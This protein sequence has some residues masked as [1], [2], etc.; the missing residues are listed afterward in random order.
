MVIA[1]PRQPLLPPTSAVAMATT[2][3]DSS[4][5]GHRQSPLSASP[6]EVASDP[7]IL[8]AVLDVYHLQIGRLGFGLLRYRRGRGAADRDWKLDGSDGFLSDNGGN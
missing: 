4:R 7:H 3:T 6:T 5:L 8:P 1:L 2:N